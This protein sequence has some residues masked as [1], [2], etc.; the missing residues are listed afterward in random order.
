MP[1]KIESL[2]AIEKR[3]IKKEEKLAEQPIRPYKE[4]SMAEKYIFN[5]VKRGA[6]IDI[7][8]TNL[9]ANF[10][11]LIT[12]HMWIRDMKTGDI[13]SK[14]GDRINKRDIEE[15]IRR[16]EVTFDKRILENFAKAI[17]KYHPDLW[18]GHYFHGWKGFDVKFLRTRFA[19]CKLNG[20]PKH[21]QV[22]YGDTWR[23]AHLLHKINGYGLQN[24]GDLFGLK[25]VK[26]RLDGDEW[27]LAKYGDKQSIDYVYEHNWKDV[28]LNY[29]IHLEM[30]EYLPIPAAYV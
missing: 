5:G 9:D 21:R 30:E 14:V 20:F 22:R 12:W 16:R 13:I 15:S 7:E 3:N 19:K 10:G 18:V 26:T 23:M 27:Q 25:G 4:M 2:H 17:E 1:T 29:K 8:T 24:V 28:M 6:Y 11:N